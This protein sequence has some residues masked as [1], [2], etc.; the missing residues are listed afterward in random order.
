MSKRWYVLQVYTG[1]E[2][3]VRADLSK[4][5]VEEE[6]QDLFGEIVVPSGEVVDRFVADEPRQEKIFPGYLLVQMEMNGASQRLVMQTPRV[7]R[8]LGGRDPMPLTGA[9]VERIFT[10]MSGKLSLSSEKE[11][12]VI[13]SEVHITGGPFVGFVGIVEGIDEEQEN[14]TVVVSIF[15]R[16]TPVVLNFR[17]IKY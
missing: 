2:D 17:Q 15:G 14:V 8:F 1:Y 7:S 9:E 4:R 11:S 10:Q 6:L 5:V 12:I 13:G 3:V 16:M